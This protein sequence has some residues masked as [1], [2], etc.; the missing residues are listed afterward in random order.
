MILDFLDCI[1]FLG[2][3]GNFEEKRVDWGCVLL[4]IVMFVLL[5]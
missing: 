1:C 3:F 4:L 2:F 5:L